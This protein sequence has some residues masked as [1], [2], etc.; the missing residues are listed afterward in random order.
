MDDIQE[1][2][3]IVLTVTSDTPGEQYF[4]SILQHLLLVRDDVFARPQY[5]KLI[6]E[7]ISQIVL[8]KSGVDPDFGARKLQIDVDDLI[9]WYLLFYYVFSNI[10]RFLNIKQLIV[11]RIH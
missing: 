11:L 4:L 10:E 5:F 8:H 6:E 7:C 2:F 1:L 9:G 3:N